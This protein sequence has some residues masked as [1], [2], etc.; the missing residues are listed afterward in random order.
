MSPHRE[1]IRLDR[2]TRLHA[3]CDGDG[4][5]D[6]DG[7][8]DGNGNGNGEN[9]G[10]HDVS[11][12]IAAGEFVAL[13]GRSGSGKTTLLGVLG[14]LDH[15][16]SGRYLLDGRDVSRLGPGAA[17]RVRGARLGF[18]FQSFQLLPTL[19]ALDNVAL[20][21]L[22]AG[23]SVRDARRRAAD[24]LD[25]FELGPWRHRRPAEMSG[26]QRQRIALCRSLVNDPDVVLADEP[27]GNLDSISAE[28][29]VASLLDLRRDR[30]CTVV[31]VTHDAALA[32]RADRVLHVADGTVA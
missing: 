6:G 22:Y 2:V 13:C 12:S 4:D 28:R 31:L 1:R 29:I 14:L 21:A 17:A 27:T 10:V 32:R 24:L 25:R 23:G 30:A 16:Q 18:V 19:S 8:D 11:L 26:G 9:A 15:A 20:P 3:S 7:D 5:G